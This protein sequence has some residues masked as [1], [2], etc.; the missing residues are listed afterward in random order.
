MHLRTPR[1]PHGA[2]VQGALCAYDRRSIRPASDVEAGVRAG[3][4]AWPAAAAGAAWTGR[5]ACG[6]SGRGQ[7]CIGERGVR[8]GSSFAV[9]GAGRP[10]QADA[11]R[12]QVRRTAGCGGRRRGERGRRGWRGRVGGSSGAHPAHVTAWRRAVD[13]PAGHGVDRDAGH[14]TGFRAGLSAGAVAGH[15]DGGGRQGGGIQGCGSRA[16]VVQGAIAGA[17]VGHLLWRGPGGVLGAGVLPSRPQCG[18]PTGR[19]RG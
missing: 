1:G 3:H 18:Q 15:G 14:G 19:S 17:G 9:G 13:G 2:Q 11:G 6:G 7:P 12:G 4:P 8:G 16:Q 5:G 10:A